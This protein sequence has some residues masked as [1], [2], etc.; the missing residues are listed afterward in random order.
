[1]PGS[2]YFFSSFTHD[3][4]LWI[5]ENDFHFINWEGWGSEK[6]NYPEP[7]IKLKCKG[8]LGNINTNWK[9]QFISDWTCSKRRRV[10]RDE[11]EF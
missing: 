4:K 3:N 8:S 9:I 6:I 1:M 10:P 7:G 2:F 11:N 5:K